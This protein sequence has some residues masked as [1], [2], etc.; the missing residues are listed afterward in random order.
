MKVNDGSLNV[1]PL[2]GGALLFVR[3][4]IARRGLKMK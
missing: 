2:K 1:F 3:L 4:K